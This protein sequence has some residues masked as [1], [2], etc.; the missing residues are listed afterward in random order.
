M[1][2][3]IKL[4]EVCLDFPIYDSRSLSFR[5]A[6]KNYTRTFNDTRS[7]INKDGVKIIQALKSINLNIKDGDR[8]A[9]MGANGSGKTTLLKLIAG[10]YAPTSGVFEKNGEVSCMLDMG[11][12]L[13]PDATGY[14][15]II[16]SNIIRG[17]DYKTSQDMIPN[18][19]EFT[20]LNDFLDLPLR[21][22]SQGMQARLAFSSAV[23]TNP[24]ILL[25]DEFFSTGDIEFS[26]KSQKKILEIMDASSILIFAS[27]DL[28]LL[29]DIC[30]VGIF[31]N[32][33]E[34]VY[35]GSLRRKDIHIEVEDNQQVGGHRVLMVLASVETE[36][37]DHVK[38]TLGI[39]GGEV[40]MEL[41]GKYRQSAPVGAPAP[42]LDNQS[43]FSE[44]FAERWA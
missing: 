38:D 18:I 40:D 4:N 33:G 28:P 36:T 5:N 35:M 17:A 12:G 37:P 19:S 13:E 43:E 9:L 39:W 8:V 44:E 24:N 22:Y 7:I 26:K 21:I 42:E 34:I 32:N 2:C 23:A 3:N 29:N 20:G 10:I 27:H 6:I 1:E 15:N 14:E 25:M 41:E 31:L 30:N 11:F 16:L